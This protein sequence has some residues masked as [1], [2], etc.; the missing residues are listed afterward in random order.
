MTSRPS[1]AGQRAGVAAE[2]V[3]AVGVNDERHRRTIDQA[4]DEPARSGRLAKSRADRHDVS[5][6][7][8]HEIDGVRRQAIRTI[9]DRLGHVLRTQAGDN[10]LAA[11]RR[12][13]RDQTGT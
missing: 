5:R 3:Q 4:G 11:V 6:H 7:V 9:L 10:G 1:R 8:E 13:D 2:G 12:G